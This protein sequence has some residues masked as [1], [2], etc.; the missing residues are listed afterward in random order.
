MARR[1]Q[2]LDPAAR[3]QFLDLAHSAEFV[4]KAPPQIYFTLLDGGVY[5]CSVRTMYRILA[6]EHE[7]NERRKQLRHPVYKRPELLA[8]GPNQLWSWDITKLRGPVKG[9]YYQLYVVLDVY[10][11]YVVGWQL[12]AYESDDLAQ[13]LL[14]ASFEKQGAPTQLTVHAD[15]GASMASSGVAG[16]LDRLDVRKTHSRPGV[17]NDNPYSESHFKTMKY[18]PDYPDRFGSQED[19][20]SFCRQFFP[21]YNEEN[22][23]SGICWL[24]PASV[25]HGHA[26]GILAGRHT[27]LMEVYNADSKRFRNGPPRLYKLPAAVWINPPYRTAN[28]PIESK[29]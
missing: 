22:Y 21:W 8:T 3:T 16:L 2:Y 7:V 10:S 6:A 5:I 12:A 23:H 13:Q 18:R 1:H 17:S 19:G 29:V 9:M 4:D 15:N 20:L 28:E 14:S 24:T 26:A 27:T 25:H 11:R